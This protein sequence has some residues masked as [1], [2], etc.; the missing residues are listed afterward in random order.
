M[1]PYL[2]IVIRSVAVYLFM[3]IALRVF[4]KK[5]LSQ[6][7]TADV[8]LILLISNSVQ[9]AM[10]GNNTSLWGG[11]AAALVLFLIS[12]ILKRLM[13]RFKK[14]SDFVQDKPEILI[15]N[16][17]TEYKTLAKL[18]ITSDEMEEAMREHGVEHYKE[19]KLAMLEIDGNISII[20]G[21]TELKQ[22][23]HKRR[24]HKTLS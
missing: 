18:G 21:E 24:I 5:E 14:L 17:K 9:N 22:S 11:L 19:V 3:V 4:G 16:G 15:H 23:H 2:D 6:L 20:S 7:N 8:I 1:H 12:Y 10:V 13:Y